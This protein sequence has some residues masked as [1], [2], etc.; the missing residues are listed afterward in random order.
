MRLGVERFE[1]EVGRGLKSSCSQNS[2]EF[3]EVDT[4][5]N[6]RDERLVKNDFY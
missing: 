5:K 1:D 3:V 2:F 6:G 4:S